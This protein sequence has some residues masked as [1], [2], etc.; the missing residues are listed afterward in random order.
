MPRTADNVSRPSE[1]FHSYSGS[2]RRRTTAAC[3]LR[4]VIQAPLIS[5]REMRHLL[6]I[7]GS[8]LWFA[9]NAWLWYA[10]PSPTVWLIGSV[11]LG[12]IF[13][14]GFFHYV[15]RDD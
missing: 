9:L 14:T 2:A 7:V 8:L 15:M 1:H 5:S 4:Q 13:F 11:V 10:R 3:I 6:A 12:I